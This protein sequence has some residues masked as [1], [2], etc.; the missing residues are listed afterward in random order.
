MAIE[1]EPV[2]TTDDTATTAVVD[3]VASQLAAV[4]GET[5]DAPIAELQRAVAT[6]GRERALLLLDAARTIEAVGGMW[7]HW[8]RGRHKRRTFGGVYFKLLQHVLDC[9]ERMFVFPKAPE[10]V[11][12]RWSERLSAVRELANERGEASVI[13]LQ[14]MGRPGKVVVRGDCAV[15]QFHGAKPPQLPKGL[16]TPSGGAA[17]YTLYIS[18]K[19]WR[20]VADALNDPADRLIVEGW[21]QPDPESQSVAIFVTLATTTALQRALRE[22]QQAERGTA[23][24][25]P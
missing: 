22:R 14:L 21:P 23:T 12:L 24:D 11:P 15:M 25:H 16:P 5:E 7:P 10:Q 18:A 2:E 8:R 20:R 3:A 4:L 17:V 9:D 1:L 6:L 13:K 19:Q